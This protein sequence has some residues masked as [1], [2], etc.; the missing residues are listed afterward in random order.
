[1]SFYIT[2]I[3][4]CNKY[5][6]LPLNISDTFYK[7]IK[8]IA[9]SIGIDRGDVLDYIYKFELNEIDNP[10]SEDWETFTDA[11]D[12]KK[13]L[14]VDLPIKYYDKLI[15]EKIYTELE[16]SCKHKTFTLIIIETDDDGTFKNTLNQAYGEIT[17][18]F[19]NY[20][21]QQMMMVK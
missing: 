6:P 13:Y 11:I 12:K 9:H 16:N 5:V 7:T 18:Y 2:Y 15:D 1:M 4:V 3:Y 8:Y 10:K 19:N 17:I 21:L 20:L 14:F